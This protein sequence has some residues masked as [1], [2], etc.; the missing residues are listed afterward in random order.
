MISA[1]GNLDNWQC[2]YVCNKCLVTSI[3][4]FKFV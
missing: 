3:Y 4:I 1:L 2:K